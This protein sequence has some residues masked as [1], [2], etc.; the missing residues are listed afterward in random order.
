MTR[1]NLDVVGPP[2]TPSEFTYTDLEPNTTYNFRI[3]ACNGRDS[4]GY[5]TNP[6]KQ[7][8][9]HKVPKRPHTI[10]LV[11]PDGGNVPHGQLET[12]TTSPAGTGRH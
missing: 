11:N 1:E 2:P 8:T 4:C 9:T 10:G 7:V 6:P 3:H 12:R 5:W